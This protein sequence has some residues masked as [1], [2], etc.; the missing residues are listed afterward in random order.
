MDSVTFKKICEYNQ[1]IVI[2]DYQRNNLQC[3][4]EDD[5]VKYIS[6]LNNPS[7]STTFSLDIQTLPVFQRKIGAPFGVNKVDITKQSGYNQHLG[8]RCITICSP[9]KILTFC[10]QWIGKDAHEEHDDSVNE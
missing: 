2:V 1:V 6:S 7:E 8:G 5:D 9:A 3:D 10:T 4:H